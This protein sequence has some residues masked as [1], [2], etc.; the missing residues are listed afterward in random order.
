MRKTRMTQGVLVAALCCL[1]NAGCVDLVP[2]GLTEVITDG[3]SD[4]ISN[5]VQDIVE[6]VIETP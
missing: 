2:N 5:F 3:I 1:C 6:G 4:A